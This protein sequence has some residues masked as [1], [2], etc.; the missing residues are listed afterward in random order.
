VA[1]RNDV[2]GARLGHLPRG[3]LLTWLVQAQSSLPLP[4]DL[5]DI[6]YIS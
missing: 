1:G 2:S 4:L 5:L 6:T 3:L